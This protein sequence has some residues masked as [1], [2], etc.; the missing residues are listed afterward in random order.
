MWSKTTFPSSKKPHRISEALVGH[1]STFHPLGTKTLSEIHREVSDGS[2]N[3]K[4][5]LFQRDG[6]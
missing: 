1:L 3:T 6:R 5:R 4:E 2:L